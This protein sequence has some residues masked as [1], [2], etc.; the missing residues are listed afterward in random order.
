MTEAPEVGWP[1]TSTTFRAVSRLILF[2]PFGFIAAPPSP[3]SLLLGYLEFVSLLFIPGLALMEVFR[4]GGEFSFAER[5]GLAFGLS[6]AIDVLV[7][8]VRTSGVLI[9]SQLMVG[10]F[11]GTLGLMLG[12]SLATFAVP[13]ALRRRVDFYVKPS[14]NDLYVLGLVLAQALLVAA[15]FSKYPIFPE[16][17]SVDFGQH[18]QITADLQAGRAT[19]KIVLTNIRRRKGGSSSRSRSP[20]LTRWPPPRSCR[21]RSCPC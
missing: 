1:G 11:P 5:L 15:H 6:M 18:V 19:M 8:V 9:G 2:F 16:F 7:L 3:H 17:R 12:V 4:L 20:R 13:V 10:I 21:S 14:R